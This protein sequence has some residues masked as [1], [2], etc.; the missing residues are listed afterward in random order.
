M[1]LASAFLAAYRGKKR[2]NI[3]VTRQE[4]YQAKGCLTVDSLT[5]ALYKAP[6]DRECFIIGGGEIYK[7]SLNFVDRVYLTR[8]KT[9]VDGDTYF[10]ELE[11]NRWELKSEL[12]VQK[13]ER[14]KY[15]MSFQRYDRFKPTHKKKEDEK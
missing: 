9:T 10:P 8:V 13:D 14:N 1:L 6:N 2:G 11:E 15:D 7:K 4:D 12:N 5:Q 3:I